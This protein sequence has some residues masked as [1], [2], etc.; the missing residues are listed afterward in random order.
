MVLSQEWDGCFGCDCRIG[1]CM[2]EMW[3][4]RAWKVK[5]RGDFFKYWSGALW[6]PIS[7]IIQR[8]LV[9]QSFWFLAARSELVSLFRQ[10]YENR[11]FPTDQELFRSQ[12]SSYRLNTHLL[13]V[14]KSIKAKRMST[15]KR[16]SYKIVPKAGEVIYDFRSIRLL[17]FRDE[18]SHE[19]L[20]SERSLFM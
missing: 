3:Q 5:R 7:N 1:L 2:V 4:L 17:E 16:S 12:L 11:V 13:V 18:R 9:N 15:P 19:K 20:V 14:A 8:L 6:Y 10:V